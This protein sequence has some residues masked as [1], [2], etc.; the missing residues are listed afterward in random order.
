[1]KALFLGSSFF[2][3]L[4][5]PVFHYLEQ[6]GY[7]PIEVYFAHYK[8]EAIDEVVRKEYPSIL[9]HSEN[10]F[11]DKMNIRELI[12]YVKSRDI[13]IIFNPHIPIDEI[14]TM[15]RTFKKELKHVKRIDL[16]HNCTN[17]IVINKR[18]QLRDFSIKEVHSC[19]Q[20]VQFLLPKLYLYLL[21]KDVIR[22]MKTSYQL[23]DRIVTLSPSYVDQYKKS[24][25]IHR[26][27]DEKLIFIPNIATQYVSKLPISNK[28]KRIVY[29]GGLTEVKSVH[30]LLHIWKQ[31]M[32]VIPD[33]ELHIVGDGPKRTEL[34]NL[35]QQLVLRDVEFCGYQ[36]ALPLIDQAAILCLVSNVEGFPT[37]FTEAMS[38][39]VVPIGF[40]SFS[41]IYDMIDHGKNGM[42]I[43][44]FDY[45]RY[46]D[47]LVALAKDDQMRIRMAEAA[48][49][50]VKEYNIPRIASMWKDLF[51]ELK[52]NH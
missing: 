28:N 7:G 43:P 21:Q 50:K 52:F 38:L 12:D 48:K 42:I 32:D 30:R 8:P 19:K 14:S 26:R 11:N 45:E 22:R 4:Y 24:I 39:G 34:E 49:Q 2:K 41:A 36:P 46:A 10:G 18:F 31:I 35:A 33:W 13:Q 23:F 15:I 47:A 44:C 37:V 16:L 25:G 3:G 1:M 20:L 9:L 17:Y 6:T 51:E 27:I 29:V 5:E 40:D